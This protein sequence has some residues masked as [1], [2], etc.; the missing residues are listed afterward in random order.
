MLIK[1]RALNKYEISVPSVPRKLSDIN[2]LGFYVPY[3]LRPLR[4]F[5][6]KI[7]DNTLWLTC[8]GHYIR[9]CFCRPRDWSEEKWE[10][11]KFYNSLTDILTLMFLWWYRVKFCQLSPS[12]GDCPLQNL[13]VIHLGKIWQ[14]LREPKVHCRVHKYTSPG[15][16][17]SKL[18]LIHTANRNYYWHYSSVYT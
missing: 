15:S 9:N 14:A 8:P 13:T 5:A 2:G 11:L 1:S 3:A 10:N 16:K 7:Q 17:L 6:G 4:H 18:N 12:T